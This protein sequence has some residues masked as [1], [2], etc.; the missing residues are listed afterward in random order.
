M[1]YMGGKQSYALIGQEATKGTSVTADKD[2]GLVQ[3][4]STEFTVNLRKVFGFGSSQMQA[5]PAGKFESSGS[6][7]FIF[8]HGRMLEYIF[9]TVAH[10]ETTTD[11]KH[12]FTVANVLPSFTLE[13][14]YSATTDVTQ[15]IAGVKL[16]SM[17]I[18][19]GLDSEVKCNVDWAGM[20]KPVTGETA[21]S[22]VV[23]TLPV[24]S[25]NDCTLTIGD[26]TATE[27][28]SMEITIN[29]ATELLHG[30]GD[31]EAV[32]IATKEF[33]IDFTATLGFKKAEID[34]LLAQTDTGFNFVFNA[35][36]GVTLGS[37]RRELNISLEKCKY[38]STP[39]TTSIGEWVYMDVSGHGFPNATGIYSV[40]NISNDNWGTV[41]P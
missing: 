9:G 8:Q 29:R 24:F 15:T 5:I 31:D 10:D 25:G 11:W 36:N 2:I 41:V 35:T 39:K 4:G 16:G 32:D 28:Q 13:D 14:G 27:V 40:D 33:S 26:A 23:S 34:R 38:N 21:S 6:I 1:A 7:E 3:T 30:F 19:A 12:T 22:A 18:S 17:K 37:G 20:K